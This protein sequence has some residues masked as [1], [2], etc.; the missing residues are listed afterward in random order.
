MRFRDV[1]AL[2]AHESRAVDADGAPETLA[3]NRSPSHAATLR[4]RASRGNR[5]PLHRGGAPTA[6]QLTNH[7]CAARLAADLDADSSAHWRCGAFASR[8]T[9]RGHHP[10]PS[11]HGEA[12]LQSLRPSNR[13]PGHG[14]YRDWHERLREP[15]AHTRVRLRPYYPHCVPSGNNTPSRR[16]FLTLVPSRVRCAHTGLL[17]LQAVLAEIIDRTSEVQLNE[18]APNM[19]GY[20]LADRQR[21]S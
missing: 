21:A 12:R 13:L 16:A 3:E 5:Q 2:D 9:T 8:S 6:R 15:T 20:R 18:W 19:D 7:M 14:R 17:G 1:E 4:A 10:T 11:G